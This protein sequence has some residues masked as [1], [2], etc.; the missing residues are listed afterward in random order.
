[1]DSSFLYVNVQPLLCCRTYTI[2]SSIG[3]FWCKRNKKGGPRCTVLLVHTKSYSKLDH[4]A[5]LDRPNLAGLNV[6]HLVSPVREQHV[7]P[8]LFILHPVQ[9]TA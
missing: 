5:K 9:L 4:L 8:D 1:M 3:R 2:K 7:G 6:D